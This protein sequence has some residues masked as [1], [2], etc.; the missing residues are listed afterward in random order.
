MMR[1]AGVESGNLTDTDWSPDGQSIL[2]SVTGTASGTDIWLLPLS[3]DKKPVR[4]LAESWEE[5]H[6]N[7]SPNGNLVAYTSNESGKYQVYVQTLPLSDRKWQVSTDG[8][9]EPRWR[10]DGRE[11]YYLSED[12]KLMVVPVRAGPFFDTPKALFQTRVA[13]GVSANRTHYVPSRDGQ[14]FLV[15][16]QSGDPSPTPITV[17]LNWTA[18]L[19]K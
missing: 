10:A 17:V 16:T 19:K 5:L 14:R 9:Y 1:A 8:G 12:R 13:A 6:G 18:G 11:I 4:Y 3:A 15:N 2:F 7:F